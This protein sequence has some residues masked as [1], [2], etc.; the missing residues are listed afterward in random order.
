MPAKLTTTINNISSVPNHT[1]A[2]LIKEFS[3]YMKDNGSS[4]HHQNNN[5]KAVTAFAKFLGDST[6]F[7]DIQKK[8]QILA[9]LDTKIN[10]E[11]NEKRWI[12]TWN[13]YLDRLKL[14]FRWLYNMRDK[15]LEDVAPQS[16]WDTPVF[17]RIKEKK[18]KRVSPYSETELWE[19]DE[20]L[21]I[22]K[23]EPYKRNKAA[24]AL[25]W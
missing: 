8:E 1:N 22:L 14:F 13:N 10:K 25:F 15:K 11:D 17:T 3:E 12:P 2:A 16:D 24:L 6:T 23:Y 4:E 5:L 21:F 18:T 20:I 7:Y 19:R 9:F